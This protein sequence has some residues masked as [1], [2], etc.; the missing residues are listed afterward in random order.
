MLGYL[1]AVALASEP[2]FNEDNVVVV[3]TGPCA[4]RTPPITFHAGTSDLTSGSQ[5][6]LHAVRDVLVDA[7][8]IELVVIVGHASR[9]E[10]PPAEQFLLSEARARHVWKQLVAG[11]VAQT[12][13]TY[14]GAGASSPLVDTEE[15]PRNRRVEFHIAVHHALGEGPTYPSHQ[16]LPW[17]GEVKPITVLRPKMER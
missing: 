7:P 15:L 9:D 12:R 11:G 16:A 3:K 17:S 14:R 5:A 1:M 10:G 6:T 8:E 13:L 2:Q 4:G